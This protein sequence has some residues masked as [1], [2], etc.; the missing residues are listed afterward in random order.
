MNH[1]NITAE[2]LYSSRTLVVNVSQLLTLH[3]FHIRPVV[4]RLDVIHILL[5]P[6]ARI[7][8][9]HDG[10]FV[11]ILLATRAIWVLPHQLDSKRSTRCALVKTKTSLTK[12]T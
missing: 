10:P 9:G 7:P 2:V 4:Y 11:A 5:R 8:L 1:N 3:V 6:A 12:K